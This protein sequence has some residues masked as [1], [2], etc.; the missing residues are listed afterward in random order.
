MNYVY[1][2]KLKYEGSQ[3]NNSKKHKSA[4]LRVFSIG[5]DDYNLIDAMKSAK[6]LNLIINVDYDR[7][8]KPSLSDVDYS[9]SLAGSRK[10]LDALAKCINSDRFYLDEA[11]EAAAKSDFK[12]AYELLKPLAERG[13]AEA[14]HHLGIMYYFGEWVEKDYSKAFSWRLKAAKQGHAA[15][16]NDV[17]LMYSEGEG[18]QKSIVESF[19]WYFLA[20]LNG[21]AHAQT[22]LANM[23][24][25][26]D[27]VKADLVKAYMWFK[28]A[29][30]DLGEGTVFIDQGELGKEAKEI[31]SELST[32]MTETQIDSAKTM[33]KN[34]MA[35]KNVQ[36]ALVA[37]GR[38]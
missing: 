6:K 4:K 18:V 38:E 22:N 3:K 8:F 12:K 5:S 35:E 24:R 37:C 20:A 9:I 27:G 26:G 13:N 30:G 11:L 25:K 14:Q 21:S 2:N 33:F 17:G 36:K 10:A 28:A 16:Q 29:S 34:C 19:N 15:A 23:Y 32:S 7:I 1:V 31:L